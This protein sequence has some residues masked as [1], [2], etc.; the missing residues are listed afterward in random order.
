MKIRRLLDNISIGVGIISP[1]IGVL[2]FE[3]DIKTVVFLYAVEAAVIAVYHIVE[4]WLTVRAAANEIKGMYLLR[5]GAELLL[6]LGA[7]TFFIDSIIGY[8]ST[9]FNDFPILLEYTWI[10]I[11]PI[12]SI[13]LHYVNK[14]KI[15]L[16]TSRSERTEQLSPI[17]IWLAQLPLPLFMC[18][19]ILV[20]YNHGSLIGLLFIVILL[21]GITEYIQV[22]SLHNTEVV[23]IIHN[24]LILRS[25]IIS[26]R[27]LI[28][29][30]TA[31]ILVLMGFF[32]LNPFTQDL[33]FSPTEN[34]LIFL[35]IV[36]VVLPL[37]LVPNITLQLNTQSHTIEI[38]QRWLRRSYR[39]IPM[40]DI[41]RVQAK[42][43]N[44][45]KVY[46]YI[47]TV[48]NGEPWKC[49]V[50]P[51]NPTEW[52]TWLMQVQAAGVDLQGL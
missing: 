37:L 33:N 3:W 20:T 43:N 45:K 1:L 18:A 30:L 7:F 41:T 15:L 34:T 39:S 5:I 16:S 27:S 31:Y 40:A 36:C 4:Y 51:F 50:A 48:K 11:I 2:W 13:T 32:A 47:F 19:Y 23:T 42:R 28:A 12:L 52:K 22:R 25:S 9:V 38:T 44:H 6:V 49:S 29:Q 21:K 10:T 24:P 26:T 17:F 14:V 35:G 8:R 46:M